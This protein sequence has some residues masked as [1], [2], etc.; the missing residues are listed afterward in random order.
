MGV[1][2][3]R[4]FQAEK[5]AQTM[6]WG[7]RLNENLKPPAPQVVGAQGLWGVA[8]QAGKTRAEKDLVRQARRLALGK[9]FLNEL[10]KASQVNYN[11]GKI[12]YL[13]NF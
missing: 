6:Q 4:K 1:G 3:R 12:T 5:S 10:R 2:R 13:L 11:P 9:Y 7:E 8:P